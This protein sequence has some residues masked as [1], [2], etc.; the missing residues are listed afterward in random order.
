[1]ARLISAV[2]GMRTERRVGLV[3]EISQGLVLLALAGA[4]VGGL[5]G[6]VAV[7]S[8]ALGG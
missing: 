4:S 6:M 7:A 5:L 1:M 8:R 2:T 3:R